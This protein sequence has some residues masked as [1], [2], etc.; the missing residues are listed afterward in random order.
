MLVGRAL[1]WSPSQDAQGGPLLWPKGNLW[2]QALNDSPFGK[3]VPDEEKLRLIFEWKGI[4]STKS[5]V[6]LGCDTRKEGK[7]GE[8]EELKAMAL[9]LSNTNQKNIS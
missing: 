4:L 2:E 5:K 6:D 3:C 9:G 1:D 7:A 8:E